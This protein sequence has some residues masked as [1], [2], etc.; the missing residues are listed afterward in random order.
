MVFGNMTWEQQAQVFI[1]F[2]QQWKVSCFCQLVTLCIEYHA[3]DINF[4]FDCD[5]NKQTCKDEAHEM[6]G[7]W[8]MTGILWFLLRLMS[9]ADTDTV[10]KLWVNMYL[11]LTDRTHDKS[12]HV[13][14]LRDFPTKPSAA[15]EP[16]VCEKSD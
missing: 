8:W 4:D 6:R 12:L 5:F 14:S 1:L 16:G 3:Y 9:S 15:G 11:F 13:R 2:I 7:L 10:G